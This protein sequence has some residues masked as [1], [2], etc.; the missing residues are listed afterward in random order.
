MRSVQKK[1][2][3]DIDVI[4]VLIANASRMECELMGDAIGRNGRLQVVDC[5]TS[6]SG[7]LS[8]IQT[9]GPD[10]AVISARLEDGEFAG[11]KLLRDLRLLHPELR[12]IIVIDADERDQVIVA[13]RGGARGVFC[14]T[15]NPKSLRRCIQRVHDGQIW[16]NS[17]QTEYIVDALIKSP[18]PKVMHSKNT[19][20]LSK[21]ANQ[22]CQL[23]ASGLSNRE[24]STKLGL[25]EHTVKN[26]LSQIFEKL[27][28]STRIE[29][30]LYTISQ[31]KRRPE[32]VKGSRPTVPTKFG[33]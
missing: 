30:V 27:G 1:S 33:S 7:V 4:R 23:A 6:Y 17:T 20:V 22:V 10:V 11:F 31:A 21:R 3:E 24:I 8:A 2:V 9:S 14:R 29:L 28:I 19:V 12:T 25:S 13:F 18:A 26:Y 15:G 32:S 16:A 5:S